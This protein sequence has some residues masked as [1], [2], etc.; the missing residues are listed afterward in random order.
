MSKRAQLACEDALASDLARHI[1]TFVEALVAG[2]YVETTRQAKRRI[3][4]S[5]ARWARHVPH[6]IA[7]I[8]E[9]C[10]DAYL[11]GVLRRPHQRGRM[12]RGTLL[13]FLEHL[14]HVDA[15][16]RRA[17]PEPSRAE[18]LVGRYVDHLKHARG[19]SD[20]SVAIYTPIVRR[21]LLTTG[22][23]DTQDLDAA[24][25]AAR[26]REYVLGQARARSCEVTRL[27]T[28]ALRSLLRFLFLE[29]HASRDLST[30]VPAVRR[31]QF[32]AVPPVLSAAEVEQVL[33][34]VDRTTPRGRRTH[35]VLLLLARLGL[36]PG[37]VAGLELDD[38]RWAEGELVVRG[39]GGSRDRLPLP[40]DVGGALAS[41][42]REDRGRSSSRRVF[43]RLRA[44]RTG[45]SG[46][47]AVSAVARDAF[48]RAGL[49]P[50][51][52]AGAHLFRHSLATRM[53]RNGAS[54]AEIAQAL[55]HRCAA[56]TRTYAKVDFAALRVVA[57]PWPV[58]GDVR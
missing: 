18:V 49:R 29:G 19:L 48:R 7:S 15:A 35:A 3:L 53:I 28:V 33:A 51:R 27:M 14:R 5:F 47:C 32:A 4:D 39:K 45:L 8:D 42:L 23:G 17:T 34:A 41:Y 50:G 38:I 10:V 46:P 57:R 26:L 16:P 36:R 22:L 54:M 30:A 55:R 31:W 20:R 56:T 21:F 37:E 25:D 58:A 12:E 11:K 2:G 52:R 6:A 44:P 43:L 40:K 24:L 1:G 9:D 13:Q